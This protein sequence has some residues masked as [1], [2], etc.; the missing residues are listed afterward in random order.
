MAL[1]FLKDKIEIIIPNS[2][3]SIIAQHIGIKDRTVGSY[4]MSENY[5]G[6][7]KFF[8]RF[9]GKVYLDLLRTK[10]NLEGML[11]YIVEENKNYLFKSN[12][13]EQL[14]LINEIDSNK[15]NDYYEMKMPII[16]DNKKY[17]KFIR[18]D[19][20]VRLFEDLLL[21]D[22]TKIVIKKLNYDTFVIYGDVIDNYKDQIDV[23]FHINEELLIDDQ[24]NPI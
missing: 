20:N 10:Q 21:G 11:N 7:K 13:I 2:E 17:M 9:R 14:T 15:K 1:Y 22:L 23:N 8:N 5:S 16:N 18:E 24:I 6:V 19:N 12:I 4:Y 3:A